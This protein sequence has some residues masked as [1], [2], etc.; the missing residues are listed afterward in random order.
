MKLYYSPG[1]CSL[2]THIVFKETNTPVTVVKTDIGAKTYEGGG[3]FLKVSPLG[4]VPALELDDGAILTEVPAIVQ[5][6]ADKAAATAIAPANGTFARYQMQS[7]LNFVATELHR[8]FAPLWNAKLPEESKVIVRD[9][10][11]TRFK[12]LDAH[13]AS[14]A[15]LMGQAYTL[16]DAYAFNVLSW[17]KP[18]NVDL[19]AYPNLTAYMGRVAARPAVQAAMKAE[20]LI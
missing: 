13:F 3:N 15:Y 20:G 7:W 6:I 9:R 1:A 5:Y 10:L 2:A 11:T 8:G 18:L 14:N 16:P 17:T 4:Y 12:H 19:S